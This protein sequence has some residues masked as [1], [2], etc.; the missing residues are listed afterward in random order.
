MCCF[1]IDMKTKENYFR[2]YFKD[3]GFAMIIIKAATKV[4]RRSIKLHVCRSSVNKIRLTIRHSGSAFREVFCCYVH[5][6][7]YTDTHA[8]YEYQRA[9]CSEGKADISRARFYVVGCRRETQLSERER[10]V[11]PYR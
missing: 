9:R 6:S 2:F 10:R 5:R 7:V 8:G 4:K 1:L 11:T 3:P